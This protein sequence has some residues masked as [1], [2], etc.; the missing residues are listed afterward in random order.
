MGPPSLALIARLFNPA[1]FL[2]LAL[3]SAL[4]SLLIA[5]VA[6]RP[7]N[8]LGQAAKDLGEDLDRPPLKLKGPYEVRAASQAFNAM[9]AR[10]RETLGERTRMLGAIT[11]DLQTPL[12][13]LRLR[14]EKIGDAELRGRALGDLSAMQLLIK[15]GLDLA[16][17]IDSPEPV[18]TVDLASLLEALVEDARDAGQDATLAEGPAVD[19]QARPQG[20]RRC[21]QN[22]IDNAVAHGGGAEV[23]HETSEGG[24]HVRVRDRGPGIPE[25]DLERVFDPFYRLEASR[26]RDTG[27]SGLGLTIARALAVRSGATL[28]LHNHPG[29]GIEAT[30]TFQRP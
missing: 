15:E 16:R 9:Q 4:L 23:S 26:S 18:S 21:L 8:D 3:F 17:S 30:L 22:L 12:T 20:L 24:V 19:V 1:Y 14:M 27:G 25:E 11:H 2:V 5:Y 6:A 7:L 28:T 10:L 29:G 13:R